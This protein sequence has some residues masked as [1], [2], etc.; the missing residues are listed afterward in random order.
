MLASLIVA[1]SHIVYEPDPVFGGDSGVDGDKVGGANK[2]P[3]SGA[4]TRG[5]G[6]KGLYNATRNI[7]IKGVRE[8]GWTEADISGKGGMAKPLKVRTLI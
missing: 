4:G 2:T 1:K 5:G 7:M 8:A 6:G 3:A